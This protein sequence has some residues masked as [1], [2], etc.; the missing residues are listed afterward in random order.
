M[1]ISF[2]IPQKTV[3]FTNKK[4][5]AKLH[6]RTTATTPFTKHEETTPDMGVSLCAL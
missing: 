1:Q 2:S 3:L 6:V 5:V 4:S